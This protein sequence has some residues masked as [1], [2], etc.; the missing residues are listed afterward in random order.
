MA[1]CVLSGPGADQTTAL[2]LVEG[3]SVWMSTTK[4][5]CSGNQCSDG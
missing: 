2:F 4:R 1:A 3:E 5:M